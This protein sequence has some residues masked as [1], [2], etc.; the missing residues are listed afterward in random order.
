MRNICFFNST[1][2]WGGGEKSHFEYAYN[3][4]K[5]NYNV[6]IITS[7][8]SVL[9][10]KAKAAQIPVF[11]LNVGNLSFLNPSK[12]TASDLISSKRRN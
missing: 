5:R 2:F 11:S 6:C 9:E 10:E 7:P 1:K 8:G 3:F 4:Q 12:L